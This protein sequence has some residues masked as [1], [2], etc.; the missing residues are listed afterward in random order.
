M[1]GHSTNQARLDWVHFVSWLKSFLL[2]ELRSCCLPGNTLEIEDFQ[3]CIML[4]KHKR[5]SPFPQAFPLHRNLSPNK[6][7]ITLCFIKITQLQ[8]STLSSP[9]KKWFR[10]KLC[11]K[12]YG[13]VHNGVTRQLAF[14]PWNV[15]SWCEK[16]ITIRGIWNEGEPHLFWRDFCI[17]VRWYSLTDLPHNLYHLN[18]FH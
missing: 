8:V 13:Y 9:V 4:D 5:A 7:K 18:C 14:C 17:G 15:S 1:G 10:K 16:P 6:Q 12:D 2:R 11:I 3:Q